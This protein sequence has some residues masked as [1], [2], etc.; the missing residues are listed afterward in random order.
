MNIYIT[1]SALEDAICEDDSSLHLVLEKLPGGCAVYTDITQDDLF[2]R[3]GDEDDI[4]SDLSLGCD[5]RICSGLDMINGIKNDCSLVLKD[6]MAVYILD[7]DEQLASNI[8]DS[9]GVICKSSKDPDISVLL[10]EHRTAVCEEKAPGDWGPTMFDKIDTEPVNSVLI[11]DR[12]LFSDDQGERNRQEDWSFT[13]G[14]GYKNVLSLLD[15]I[16]PRQPRK[17]NPITV[18]I[19]FDAFDF[20]GNPYKKVR[21]DDLQRRELERRHFNFLVNNLYKDINGLRK[22]LYEVV[23]ELLSFGPNAPGYDKTHNRRVLT[24]YSEL[25][26][27]HKLAAFRDHCCEIDQNII[28]NTLFAEGIHNRSDC[29]ILSHDTKLKRFANI[30]EEINRVNKL[31]SSYLFSYCAQYDANIT[32]VKNKLIKSFLP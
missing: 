13:K 17:N 21:I 20:G 23:V 28:F 22:G 7:I 32:K 27:E 6:P 29:P 8:Q 25:Y 11:S 10:T 19:C 16:L 5:V 1:I 2:S 14:N 26:A 12:Y 30:I 24:N 15:C 4:L 3:I 18:L 31:S 9:F